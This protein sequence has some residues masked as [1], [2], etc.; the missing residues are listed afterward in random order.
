MNGRQAKSLRT[1]AREIATKISNDFLV[2]YCKQQGLS[3][4]N[5]SLDDVVSQIPRGTIKVHGTVTHRTNSVRKLYK[6]LKRE[7]AHRTSNKAK[8]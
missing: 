5:I 3:F 6:K 4:D 1:H 2:L 8:H 7:H